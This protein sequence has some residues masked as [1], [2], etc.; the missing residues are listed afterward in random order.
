[1]WDIRIHPYE[2][3]FLSVGSD[4]SISL[5]QVPTIPSKSI[6]IEL[7]YQHQQPQQSLLGRFRK[8]HPLSLSG[9]YLMPT[10]CSWIGDHDSSSNFIVTYQEPVIS[11]FDASTGKEKGLINY[12]YDHSKHLCLQ[13]INKVI[14]SEEQGLIVAGTEDNLI[15][16]F[17]I[18]SHKQVKSIV[19]HADAV[20]SLLIPNLHSLK[21]TNTATSGQQSFVSGGHD[22]ALRAW[23]LRTF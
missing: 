17:D 20:T 22:G 14:V 9:A 1:V 13:Q 11:L 16:F 4:T 3:I 2:N 10:S 21:S 19:A 6:T 15:R 18:N 23:D 8:H 5:W 7:D 12:Q